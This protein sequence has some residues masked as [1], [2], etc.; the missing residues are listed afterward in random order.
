[1]DKDPCLQPRAC[2]VDDLSAFSST[3]CL[4]QGVCLLRNMESKHRHSPYFSAAQ[5]PSENEV[6]TVGCALWGLRGEDEEKTM[7][8]L[9]GSCGKGHRS[10]CWA[11]R[12]RGHTQISAA[13]GQFH[14]HR[15]NLCLQPG[16]PPDSAI[17]SLGVSSVFALDLGCASC[18]LQSPRLHH[19]VTGSNSP[20]GSGWGDFLAQP[21]ACSYVSSQEFARTNVLHYVLLEIP[22]MNFVSSTRLWFI[23]SLL[24]NVANSQ[25]LEGGKSEVVTQQKWGKVVRIYRLLNNGSYSSG[26][27]TQWKN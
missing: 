25:F 21:G 15:R 13:G 10:H 14:Q 2:G 11:S 22:R 8:R 9:P 7:L 24:P 19:S 18:G 17:S 5:V 20:D 1:M 26:H 16:R 27:D 3:S 12:P 6:S 4:L 23:K